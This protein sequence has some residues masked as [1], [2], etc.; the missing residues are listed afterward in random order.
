[1]LEDLEVHDIRFRISECGCNSES[2][3]GEEE[4]I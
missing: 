1:M 3:T 2:W 4:V